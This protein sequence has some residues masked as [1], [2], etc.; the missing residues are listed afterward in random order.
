MQITRLNTCLVAG[1]VMSLQAGNAMAVPLQAL[2]DGMQDSAA[3]L[4][5]HHDEQELQTEL[6]RHRERAGWSLF[7]GVDAGRYSELERSG[8]EKYKG[9]GAHAGLRYPLL[10]AMQVR[11]A[12]IV[13]SEIAL[14]KA[15][16]STALV[17]AEQ[18]QQ[19]RQTYIDWWRKDAQAQ[20]CARYQPVAA[21]EKRLTGSRAAAQQ[22][23]VSERLWLEQ[24]WDNLL[25]SCKDLD[26][27]E[28]GLR[29][30]L[31]YLHGAELAAGERPEPEALP[32][33]PGPIA[34]WMPLLEEHP[35]VLIHHDEARSLETLPKQRWTDRVDASFSV[36]QHLDRRSDLSGQG[37]GTVAAVHFE[38]PI[39]S[40]KNRG[41][42]GLGE[43]RYV[44]AQHRVLDSRQHMLQMLEKTLFDYHQQL[45][46]LEG[47]RQQLQRVQRLIAEQQA[48][49]TMDTEEGFIRLRQARL[50]QA[51]SELDLINDW[52]AGWSVLAQLQVLAEDGLPVSR[53][54][55][56]SWP[57]FSAA[58]GEVPGLS[59]AGT[60]A[61]NP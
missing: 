4:A 41:R 33:D 42:A 24:G 30:Q 21:K 22:L 31:A 47:R 20:W 54:T 39:G 14:D 6:S 28:A 5:S 46:Q 40:M 43:S 9:M 12:A 18:Q 32:L 52:H 59:A 53:P 27:H 49:L 50:E 58:R 36:S 25:R 15:R 44:A 38:V 17:R 8:R 56:W 55:S 61:G 35:A 7:G 3:T 26:H 1:L 19:L 60:F 10:N 16:H 57:E 11:K 34:R 51:G 29:Q 23:R 37:S 13:D 2:V 48:R 45:R